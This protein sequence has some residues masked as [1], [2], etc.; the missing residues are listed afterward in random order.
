MSATEVFATPEAARAGTGT[1]ATP[2]YR[3]SRKHVLDWLDSGS[4]VPTMNELLEP[5]GVT[6]SDGERWP[7]GHEDSKEARIGKACGELC[8]EALNDKIRKWWLAVPRGANVP[9]W[10]LACKAT[11]PDGREG[12]VLVEAKAHEREF[13]NG[14]R[15]KANG[16]KE[17]DVQIYRAIAEARE[18]LAA[19]GDV[20]I[21]R[22]SWY[23]LSNRV[24]FAWKLASE[25]VPTV[26]IYL[27]FTGD[28]GIR[29]AEVPLED[30][31]HWNAVVSSQPVLP[32]HLWEARHYVNGNDLWFL[33]RSIPCL[34]QSPPAVVRPP[35]AQQDFANQEAESGQ[36]I[37]EAR[38]L[39][40]QLEALGAF[41]PLFKQKDISFGEMTFPKSE[42]GML[43]MPHFNLRE[44]GS[45]FCRMAYEYGWVRDFDWTAWKDSAEGQLLRN[46]SA[47][48]QA[49]VE[50]L[51]KML[52][53]CIRQ[54][55]FV[56]GSLGAHFESGLL[57]AVAQRAQAILE[58]T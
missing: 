18:G 58:A 14:W 55:R 43:Q 35:K 10:D 31:A 28:G 34:E 36:V 16:R 25:G 47:I 51:S 57:L 38:E 22:D 2:K 33:L 44:T 46:I 17:N 8:D 30:N 4:F 48:A 19:F 12:L 53:V 41:A 56:E 7:K 26:L 9:N 32:S 23:Q 3:G 29:K 49:D 13:L 21:S 42:K 6:I 52:T 40:E 50:Q 24:A 1:K 27:G 54:D 37:T 45:R 11:F 5:T 15:G 39:R 20:R